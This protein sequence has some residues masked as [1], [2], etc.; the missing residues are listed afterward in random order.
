MVLT[1][2][3]IIN[4]INTPTPT[5]DHTHYIHTLIEMQLWAGQE[6]DRREVHWI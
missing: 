6:E 2:F 1:G 3:N 5:H 4:L